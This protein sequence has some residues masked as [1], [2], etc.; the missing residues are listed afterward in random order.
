MT[1]QKTASLDD[2]ID[3]TLI[4]MFM[5]KEFMLQQEIK[6]P[7]KLAEF[8]EMFHEMM[9]AFSDSAKEKRKLERELNAS[10]D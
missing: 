10:K 2:D 6:T 7:Q 8:V 4:G 5:V 9:Q 1:V 3:D